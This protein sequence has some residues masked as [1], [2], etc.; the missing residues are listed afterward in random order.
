MTSSWESMRRKIFGFTYWVYFLVCLSFMV[1]CS[2][3]PVVYPPYPIHSLNQYQYY[4]E[5]NGLG[6]GISLLSDPKENKTY[7]GT[8][9]LA[10]GIL[11]LFLIAKNLNTESTFLLE[12]D[13]I[14]F[15]QQTGTNEGTAG[16]DSSNKETLSGLSVI[17]PLLFVN[18]WANAESEFAEQ[19]HNLA[20]KEFRSQTL[21][22]G[23]QTNG[24]VYFRI[25]LNDRRGS[26]GGNEGRVQIEVK[27]IKSKQKYQF[28]FP[29]SLKTIQ[30]SDT[31]S[32]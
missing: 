5:K 24:F 15:G 22:P 29:V 16:I 19:K 28:I 12:K 9:L 21:S 14:T 32:S 17:A 3:T 11:P 13:L 20:L 2:R 6:V 31:P 30:K 25:P 18:A 23:R 4:Q 10:G 27:D 7:F 8:N 1:G 26:S